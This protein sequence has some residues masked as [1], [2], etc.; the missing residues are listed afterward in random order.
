MTD[1]T[2]LE[3]QLHEMWPKVPEEERQQLL[4][5]TKSKALENCALL[6]VI[7]CS[8]AIGLQMPAIL[9]VV[10]VTLPV[11][12]QVVAA[13]LWLEV[14]PRTLIQY[15]VASLTAS[16]F[17]QSLNSADPSVKLI[18]KGFLQPV[19]VQD[20]VPP[21]T[22]ERFAEELE[23]EVPAPREVWISLFPDSL[24]MISESAAGAQLEFGHSTLR[25]FAVALDTPDE[26][27]PTQVESRLLI[28]TTKDDSVTGRWLLSSPYPSM[29]V[30]C[31]RKI[32][33]FT[34]RSSTNISE[35][36]AIATHP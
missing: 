25:D 35:S 32:R 23:A 24:V 33:F 6:T 1:P 28:Q 34:E 22:Q 9:L 20:D 27:D 31:E 15:F 26:T 17:A 18:F 12:Y 3:Q 10:L 13:R 16:Q 4:A 14:K 2:P 19:P 5:Y 7:G 8:T 30:A 11:L 36:G 29:L 21:E